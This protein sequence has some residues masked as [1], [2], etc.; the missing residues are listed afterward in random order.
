MD[1]IVSG[2]KQAGFKGELKSDP[3]TLDFYSHDASMFELRPKLVASPQNAKDVEQLVTFVAAK[4]KS[5]PHLSLTGR[6]AG[7]DMSGGAINDSIIVD[8][9]AHFTTITKVTGTSA[10]AQPGALYRDFEPETLKHKALM[11]S[12]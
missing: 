3:A 1:E 10:H 11:P 5:S 2:L 7:T 4:K 8:F 12:Y 6:S 9:R